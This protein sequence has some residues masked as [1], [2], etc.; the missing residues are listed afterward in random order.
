VAAAEFLLE[1]RKLKKHFGGVKA[2][3][4]VDFRVK[5]GGLISII[6]PNGAGKTTFFN[7]I[8]GTMRP[9]AGKIFFQGR[10]VTGYPAFKLAL[11]GL[12]RSYQITNI[13]PR[14]TVLE[15]VRLAC[16]SAG[17][18]NFNFWQ[19][20]RKFS[21]YE[22]QAYSILE[23]VRLQGRELQ[24][25]LNL[26]QGDKRKLEI[27]I[28]LARK[29]ELLLLDEPTAGISSDEI[30]EITSLIEN[31]KKDEENQTVILVEHRMDVV[32]AISDRITVFN[33]G[34]ILA[35]GTPREI[36]E[37]EDVQRAYLGGGGA[38]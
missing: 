34:Q 21:Q 24:P 16:Q 5:G 38:A 9:G 6:G 29:P 1:T 4:G 19:H 2:V 26:P 31:L 20:Y 13:F 33:R 32:T 18:H 10:D 11:L 36:M 7:L 23:K 25:T 28:A 8:S 17:E 15:N 27:G 14:L 3:D 35:E 22:E 30:P 37:N 12:G